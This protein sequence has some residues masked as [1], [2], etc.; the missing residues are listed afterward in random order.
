MDRFTPEFPPV[1][2]LL[3]CLYKDR[4]A[5]SFALVSSVEEEFLPGRLRVRRR[6]PGLYK[7]LFKG[8]SS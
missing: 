2:L 5:D 7:K 1:S 6:A 8:E 4:P 3:R